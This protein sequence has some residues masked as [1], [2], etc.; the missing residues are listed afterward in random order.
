MQAAGGRL[1]RSND[2]LVGEE[3]ARILEEKRQLM[4]RVY[5]GLYAGANQAKWIQQ[6]TAAHDSLALCDPVAGLNIS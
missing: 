2:H 3:K 5:S 1:E 6:F 4:A